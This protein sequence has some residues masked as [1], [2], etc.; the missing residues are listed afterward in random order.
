MPAELLPEYALVAILLYA[1]QQFLR[2]SPSIRVYGCKR[3]KKNFGKI[4]ILFQKRNTTIINDKLNLEFFQTY[5]KE[6]YLNIAII[7]ANLR[8]SDNQGTQY[9]YSNFNYSTPKLKIITTFQF[10]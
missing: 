2:K 6:I 4:S 9:I 7:N 3:E 8:W 1:H 10:F 5:C